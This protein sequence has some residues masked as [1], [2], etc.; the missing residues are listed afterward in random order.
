MKKTL[1]YFFACLSLTVATGCNDEFDKEGGFSPSLSAHY[2]RPSELR[3]ES[4]TASAFSRTFTVESF[5][6][7]WRFSEVADW[8]S[9]SPST[10]S[11]STSVTLSVEENGDADNGRTAIFYLQ[12]ADP[13]WNFERAMS[14]T[15]GKAEPWLRVEEPTIVFGGMAGEQTVGV[16]SNCEWT[17]TCGEEW[18]TLSADVKSGQ[19]TVGVGVNPSGDYRQATVYLSYGNGRQAILEIRQSPTE[20]TASAYR[21]EYENAASK[22]DVTIDSESDWSSR[23]SDS[24]I[25]VSPSSGRAGRTP[26]AI[27][28]APNTSVSSRSGYVSLIA[29]GEERI[30]IEI[31]QK[32]IYIEAPERLTFTSVEESR[33]LSLRSNTN[34]SVASKPSWITLSKESGTGNSEITVSATDNPSTAQRTGEIVFE[35]SGLSIQCRVEVV[36]AG[37]SFSASAGLIEFSPKSGQQMFDLITDASWSSSKTG[38]WFDMTPVSGH[39]NATIRVSAEENRTMDDRNG[40]IDYVYGDK[41]ATVNVHQLAQYLTIEDRAFEF[42]STGGS[43]RIELSTSDEW[44]AETEGD[45]AWLGLSKKSGNGNAEIVVTADDNPSVNGRT[46]AVV[47]RPKYAQSVRIVITQKPRHLSVSSQSI[48][49]FADGG[50]SGPVAIDTDGRFEIKSDA[51]WFT[52]DR[53]AG[54]TFTVTAAQNSTGDTRTGKITIS[55][56][57]LKE[58]SLALELT[59]MQAAKGGSFI[60]GGYPE[61]SDWSDAGQGRLTITITGYTSDKN[62]NSYGRGAL[63]V[64]AVGRRN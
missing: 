12:S 49:F 55:L 14:V 34:W 56:T 5:E 47:I 9:L 2:L 1:L 17:A 8:L 43:H 26:V 38:N 16:V 63:K 62:W 21:L 32:G 33:T 60:V 54:N 27:E 15:Q 51:S 24:W 3:F 37:K 64:K 10:G 58:G 7:P 50:T 48:Q 57:D 13:G 41:T 61:D 36:Q 6:T 19:L 42:G 45:A 39:G 46:S 18:V 30:Q 28:V 22:Y 44:T 11:G 29:G 35:Q 23:V 4:T 53:G 59:V 52:V 31:V 40:R 20:L 25:S